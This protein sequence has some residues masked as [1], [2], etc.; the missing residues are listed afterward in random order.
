MKHK[1]PSVRAMELLFHHVPYGV[2]VV[3]VDNGSQVYQLLHQL[4]KIRGDWFW[5]GEASPKWSNET[6][7]P[8][9]QFGTFRL[10]SRDHG[11]LMVATK[12]PDIDKMKGWV[13]SI[14][15]K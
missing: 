10:W 15:N 4:S 6:C 11:K 12:K 8:T 2:E 1:D 5:G 9:F 14:V 7:K 3:W 13:D